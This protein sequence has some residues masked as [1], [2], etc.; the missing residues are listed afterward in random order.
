MMSL[1]NFNLVSFFSFRIKA[2]EPYTKK[3]CRKNRLESVISI[4]YQ[5]KASSCLHISNAKERE[6]ERKKN[7]TDASIDLVYLFR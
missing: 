4:Q 5:N 2:L 1:S 7:G 6:R 3:T